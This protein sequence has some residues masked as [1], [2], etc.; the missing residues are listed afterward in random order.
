[1]SMT[2]PV[3]DMLTRIRNAGLVGHEDLRVPKSR[4]KM[5]IL[6]ILAAEG[7]IEGFTAD[8]N[9]LRVRLRFD[10]SRRPIIQGLT[11][12]STPGRRHYVGKGEI[13]YVRNGLG[14]AIL[15][16]PRGVLTDHAARSAGVGGEVICYVW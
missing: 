15:T 6:K 1:M 11:R 9:D 10:Q 13:P 5:E 8:G 16:T 3:A 2:D 4:L 12:I 7:F 14:V